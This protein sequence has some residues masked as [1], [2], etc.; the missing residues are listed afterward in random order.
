MT[1][2]QQ[3]SPAAQKH[4]PEEIVEKV[5][6]TQMEYEIPAVSRREAA[7]LLNYEDDYVTVKLNQMV[8]DGF[9]RGYKTGAGYIYW[10]PEEEQSGGEVNVSSVGSDDIDFESI[11][12]EEF[13]YEK[14]REIAEANLEEFEDDTWWES[15]YEYWY[16]TMQLGGIMFGF[17]FGIVL[18]DSSLAEFSVP[19]L[20]FDVGAVLFVIGGSVVTVAAVL[21]LLFSLGKRAADQGWVPTNPSFSRPW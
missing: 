2:E 7:K 6:Q 14:A 16:D 18:T 8:D 9:L 3:Q 15:Q 21:M 19:Q 10:V 4:S 5:E 1:S 11:D 17:G 20:I 12:P 13:S